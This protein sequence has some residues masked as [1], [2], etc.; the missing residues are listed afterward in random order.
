M[1]ASRKSLELVTIM[2]VCELR[3][4]TKWAKHFEKEIAT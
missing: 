3:I 2:N 4:V 1:E